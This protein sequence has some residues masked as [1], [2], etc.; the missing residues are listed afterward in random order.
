MARKSTTDHDN[1]LLYGG[2]LGSKVSRRRVTVAPREERFTKKSDEA[3]EMISNLDLEQVR[4]SRAGPT[5]PP[6][7][8]SLPAED[9]K[10]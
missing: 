6:A 10:G 7:A 3:R 1:N 4:S 8:P 9:H 2:D 5:I